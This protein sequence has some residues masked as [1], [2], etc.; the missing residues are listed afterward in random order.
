[1]KRSD[2]ETTLS[3]IKAEWPR[4][5]RNK[6]LGSRGRARL[7]GEGGDTTADMSV[8]D[9]SLDA[10]ETVRERGASIDE[11][12]TTRAIGKKRLPPLSTV[13]QV[14]FAEDFDLGNP[15][16]FDLV[17]ER[18]KA[19]STNASGTRNGSAVTNYDVALNQMLQEKLS[20]YSDVV[21]QHLILEISA[22]S[23]SF[24]AALE[25][26]KDLEAES[27]T[28]LSKVEELQRE[29][30][31]RDEGIA[32]TGLEVVRAQAKRREIVERQV[33]V[34]VIHQLCEKR[35]LCQLLVQNNE[36]NEA[37]DVMQDLDSHI[38]GTTKLLPRTADSGTL[39]AHV[40][41][42]IASI[43]S[44]Q[45]LAPQIKEMQTNIA[46]QLE[47]EL[48][49]ILRADAEDRIGRPGSQDSRFDGIQRSI[50]ALQKGLNSTSSDGSPLSPTKMGAPLGF[51]MEVEGEKR[52]ELS[53]HDGHLSQR[54]SVYITGLSRTHGVGHLIGLYREQVLRMAKET[55]RIY[56][57]EAQI[58]DD[59]SGEWRSNL[60]A[61]LEDDEAAQG[62]PDAKL[63]SGGLDAAN[64]LQRLDQTQF[65]ALLKTL[66]QGMT[67]CIVAV[68]AQKHLLLK[69]LDDEGR[70][71][72]QT[73]GAPGPDM[74]MPDGVSPALPATMATM[75]GDVCS[76]TH[77]F[78]SRLLS[79]RSAPHVRL[80]LPR[81]LAIFHLAWSFI[82]QS[83]SICGRMIVGLR[84]VALNQAKAW[85]SNYHRVH[86]ERAAKAVEEELWAQSEVTKQQQERVALIL[87]SATS[88]PLS[89]LLS[90]KDIEEATDSG[91]T[92]AAT[93]RT[94]DDGEISFSKT[95]TIDEKQYFVVSATT[96]VLTML[97]DYLQ[98][99]INLPLLTTEIMGR[100]VEFLKQ[101]NSRTCQ[102]VLGAGAM[103]SA[104]LKNITAKHLALASQSLSVMTV[105]IPYI[106]EAVRRHLNPRQAVMLVEF[107][108]LRR[109]YQEHQNEIHSKLVAI[110]SDR[111][112]VHCRA[113]A[114]VDWNAPI[115]EDEAVQVIK[116]MMDLVK[117][118]TTLHKVL[119]KYLQAGVVESVI[120][121]VLHS[122]DKRVAAELRRLEL[123]K[124]MARKRVEAVLQAFDEKLGTLRYVEWKPTDLT[125]ALEDM[126]K[127]PDTPVKSSLDEKRP[128]SPPQGTPAS[129]APITSYKP[130]LS[131]FARK[132]QQQQQALTAAATT[133]SQEKQNGSDRASL[134]S[135]PPSTRQSV[136]VVDTKRASTSVAETPSTVKEE[137][138][139]LQETAEEADVT[140]DGP[141][142][143]PPTPMK[144]R[145]AEDSGAW[146]PVKASIDL[147]TST[148]ESAAASSEV[149][150]PDLVPA[151][152]L[153]DETK[154]DT[155]AASEVQSP[156]TPISTL[157]S[158]STG[159]MTLQQRL[160]EAARRRAQA[161]S[162]TPSRPPT[163]QAE[164][165]DASKQDTPEAS[166]KAEEKGDVVESEQKTEEIAVGQQQPEAQV[167][168]QVAVEQHQTDAQMPEEDV[169]GSREAPREAATEKPEAASL[170]E[171]RPA[172]DEATTAHTTQEEGKAESEEVGAQGEIVAESIDA[173]NQVAQLE[174]AIEPA[175]DGGPLAE[176]S[177]P[178]VELDQGVLDE[179]ETAEGE[180]DG[181]EEGAEVEETGEGV[182]EA[183]AGSKPKG[184]KKKRKQKKKS[185]QKQGQSPLLPSPSS[186]MP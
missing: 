54:V 4:F 186:P 111:L 7:E 127:A 75:I 77:V 27:R 66:L 21:E 115:A 135:I 79:L 122:I 48:L 168:E 40:D 97:I 169:F 160:A 70:R 68:D 163:A 13:P 35:D 80:P 19:A 62:R 64:R 93:D 150:T 58:P 103:R 182:G 96:D 161:N 117:E 83:E 46:T 3:S 129:A 53:T 59:V 72:V 90:T 85:L 107:D 125:E 139:R 2:I 30:D 5:Q 141:E 183:E 61:L 50:A 105:L 155:P 94:N 71:T 57:S 159:R 137:T 67:S 17:T 91:S 25:N 52:S 102:V 113:L 101:F 73:D 136:E 179:A 133:L 1:V 132:Q 156:P 81:F 173:S 18:Y 23:S 157:V 118:T 39:P 34:G 138:E 44:V 172:N 152:P 106:R 180:E 60:A 8:G 123:R 15:Y 177:T 121:Q 28:C 63:G 89:L 32:K 146:T 12:G 51:S 147:P 29:M 185:K 45:A 84:G 104:G 142:M 10:D 151:T 95:L 148:A 166:T 36:W 43:S 178:A 31:A 153:K 37:L 124:V 181:E 131:L 165:H 158:P 47:L 14:F 184:K 171:V 149:L 26:L 170:E 76:T 74:I 11:E 55:M 41:L 162:R 167:P 92:A 108:K 130:R 88:D 119:C 116:P 154:I 145:E 134:D 140:V 128:M 86:I 6:K 176:V 87:D 33:A 82:L 22:R 175:T 174:S 38:K 126:K 100:I 98:I 110:M 24:F 69:L 120:G 56:L 16:T 42:D 144:D 164:A 49:S 143:P 65:V 109:D 20:Y 114:N 9:V 78:A 112:T 99:V